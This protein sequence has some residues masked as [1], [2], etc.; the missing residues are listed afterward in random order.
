VGALDSF[1]VPRVAQLINK[2][3]QF[4][5]TGTRYSEAQLL[6]LSRDP[7]VTISHF[8]LTDRFGDNGLISVVVLRQVGDSLDVDTWV[9]SCRVLGRS[10]EEFIANEIA[11]IARMRNARVIAG[12]YRPSAKNKMVAN[13]YQRLGFSESENSSDNSRWI[14]H[15]TRSDQPFTT[16]VQRKAAATIAA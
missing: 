8:R 7:N 14:F 10:M 1:S 4:H 16:Q 15:I 13:L 9:M 5:L 2:S 12:I 3:N 11:L 6:T